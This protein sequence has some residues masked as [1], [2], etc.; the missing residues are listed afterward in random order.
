MSRRARAR[1]DVE[2]SWRLVVVVVTGH[3][4]SAERPIEVGVDGG[5][6]S[7]GRKM[8]RYLGQFGRGNRIN[9]GSNISVRSRLTPVDRRRLELASRPLDL[10]QEHGTKGLDFGNDEIE[11]SAH[12][13]R[14]SHV[15]VHQQAELRHQL[16]GGVEQPNKL[17]L[18]I[19]IVDRQ[20]PKSDARFHC[21]TNSGQLLLR[22]ATVAC[23][24]T[25]SKPS[26]SG[27]VRN[28]TVACDHE[29]MRD[30]LCTFGAAVA[31][32]VA[33]ACIHRPGYLCDRAA[34]ECF[35]PRLARADRDVGL[36]LRQVEKPV[37][38]HQLELAGRGS[39]H[40]KR[41]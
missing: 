7:A 6:V 9:R 30:I 41:R 12:A 37:S 15:A 21:R 4:A 38:Y 27:I 2:T 13:R 39:V 32:D 24:A 8:P 31:F 22:A 34:D 33:A 5:V 17:S 14:A 25:S 20:G 29:M 28:L 11:K 23:G 3:E 19:P 16:R 18:P 40:E 26:R 10:L 35:V 36:P 1:K